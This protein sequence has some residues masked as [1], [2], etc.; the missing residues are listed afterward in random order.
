MPAFIEVVP[1]QRQV[2]DIE[3][4]LS[5]VRNGLKRALSGAINDTGRWVRTRV[6]RR[7]AEL[8]GLKQKGIRRMN[9][10]LTL[11]TPSTLSAKMR[12]K[13]PAIPVK[14]LSPQQKKTGVTYK[15][16]KGT[17]R[18]LIL[19]AFIVKKFG[20]HVFLRAGRERGPIEKQYGP[21]LV[22]LIQGEL[23]RIE[24]ETGDR[25]VNRLAARAQL[26]LDR[27]R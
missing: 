10:R 2:Q 13:S 19:H 20:S 4:M 23:P 6:V 22:D 24:I 17:S 1:N 11:S 16:P 21:N 15:A 27:G 5:G 14:V 18:T 25:L 12:T 8:S 9:V 7:L 3:R 26:L